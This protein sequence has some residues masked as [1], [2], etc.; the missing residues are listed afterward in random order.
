[1]AKVGRRKGL[2]PSKAI[3]SFNSRLTEEK[4]LRRPQS[5]PLGK[6]HAHSQLR[7]FILARFFTSLF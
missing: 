4:L 6:E 1:M 7:Y 5:I 3:L 2:L